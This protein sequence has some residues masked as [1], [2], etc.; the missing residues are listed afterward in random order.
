MEG[1]K[2]KEERG[3]RKG[4]RR[5]GGGVGGQE[6]EEGWKWGVWEG[7]GLDE[8]EADGWSGGG[9]EAVCRRSSEQNPTSYRQLPGALSIIHI[10]VPTINAAVS[11]WPSLKHQ[12]HYEQTPE[13]HILN[14]SYC[15]RGQQ[16]QTH[17][18][19]KNYFMG[20]VLEHGPGHLLLIWVS[21]KTNEIALI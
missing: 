20:R 4:G 8:R 14:S 13:T 11:H 18:L 16:C 2:E 3:R 19:Y 6:V 5:L 10:Q 1:G 7:N 9:G 17:R 15:S 12:N 21:P